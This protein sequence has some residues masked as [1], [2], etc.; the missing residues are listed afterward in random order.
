MK[1]TADI[2]SISKHEVP[3]WFHDA[4]FGIFIHWGLY[5]VPAF[6][7]TGIDMKNYFTQGVEHRLKNMPY[8]EWYLNTMKIEGSPTQKYHEETYGKDFS[9]DEFV[10][11]FNEAVKKWNP[12]EM[13]GFFK[14]IGARYVVLVTRHCDGFI[15]WPTKQPNPNKENYTSPRDIVG[16]LTKAVKQN[17]IK[18]GFY[19]CSAWEWTFNP[20]PL[21]DKES[22]EGNYINPPE[23][24][25]YVNNHWH[26]LIDEY[27]PSILWSDMGYPPGTNVNEIFAYF[28]NKNPDGVVND[29]WDQY[30]PKEKNFRKNH[31]DFL[32]PEY[33]TFKKIQK[34][35]FE[36]CRGIGNSFGYNKFETEKHYLSSEELIRMLVDIVSKNGNLLLN[37]GPK[38]DGTIPEFQKQRLIDLGKWL[39]VNSEAIFDTRPWKKPRARTLEGI[40][41]RFTQKP[42][43]LYAILLDKPKTS[44]FTIKDLLIENIVKIELL[45]HDNEVSWAQ[46][47]G[48]LELSLSEKLEDAPAYSFK[49]KLKNIS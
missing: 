32:T 29:R 22:Y 28:Y 47:D 26:E 4:K 16:E 48:N 10:P 20:N 19:Y 33:R 49:I 7:V 13:A 17:G 23:Y 12:D 1:F 35:K 36:V 31:K 9:Y 38:A 6:A 45:G 5:S 18:M 25:Q 40:N 8:S 3:E 27:N 43:L 41:L 2:E 14:Q 42:G 15:L 24:T 11:M 39:D 44:Q 30:L 37:V 46:K 34:T 21:M